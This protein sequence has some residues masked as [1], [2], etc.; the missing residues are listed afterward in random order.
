VEVKFEGR[1]TGSILIT[2][3]HSVKSSQHFPSDSQL[4]K[5]KANHIPALR[6]D[7]TEYKIEIRSDMCPHEIK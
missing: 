7:V 3:R 4:D 6:I 2:L 1:M 5:S